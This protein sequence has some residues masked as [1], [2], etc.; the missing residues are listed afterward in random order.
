M[1][2]QDLVIFAVE[3]S[4]KVS[5]NCIHYFIIRLR[6]KSSNNRCGCVFTSAEKGMKNA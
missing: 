6:E 1:I 2:P 4:M 5:Q 3:N